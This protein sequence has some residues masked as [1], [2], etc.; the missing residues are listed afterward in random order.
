MLLSEFRLERISFFP[1]AF[2]AACLPAWFTVSDV[3]SHCAPPHHPRPP[4][5]LDNNWDRFSRLK[6]A[7]YLKGREGEGA[8]SLLVHCSNAY[9]ARPGL[10]QT[11]EPKTYSMFP[12]GWQRATCLDPSS[13]ASKGAH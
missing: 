7:S 9:P 10:A 2:E 6:H 13:V 3:L 5:S 8:I 1:P 12:T 4:P 11:Q